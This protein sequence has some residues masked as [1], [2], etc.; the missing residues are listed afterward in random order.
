MTCYRFNDVATS[1]RAQRNDSKNDE[2]FRRN[3]ITIITASGPSAQALIAAA[4]KN[5][6][7]QFAA[8]T[9]GLAELH[10]GNRDA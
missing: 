2:L 3:D 7:H 9:A 8:A 4:V 10:A 1:M 6:V 5:I